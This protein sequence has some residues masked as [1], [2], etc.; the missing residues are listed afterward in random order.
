[1]DTADLD[2]FNPEPLVHI[3]DGLLDCFQSVTLFS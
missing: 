1:M 3:N 2:N